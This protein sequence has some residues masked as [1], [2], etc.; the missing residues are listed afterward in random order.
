[1]PESR[2]TIE[3]LR[4]RLQTLLQQDSGADVSAVLSAEEVSRLDIDQRQTLFRELLTI[5]VDHRRRFGLAVDQAGYEQRFAAYREVIREVLRGPGSAAGGDDDDEA[6]TVGLANDE[7][8]TPV[9]LANRYTNLRFHARGGL[10]E[11]FRAHD[12]AL[13]RDIAVKFIRPQR[14]AE[15]AS[16]EQFLLEGEITGRLDHPGVV[17]VYG[18][19]ETFDGRSFLAMRFIDGK[20]MRAVIDEFHARPAAAPG[21]RRRELNRL[22]NHL[23]AACNVVAYAHSRGILHR[24]IKPDNIMI[25]RFNETLVVDW[26][27]AVPIERDERGRASGEQTIHVASGS[28]DSRS[29]PAAGTIGYFSPEALDSHAVACG[30]ASDIYSLGG[31]LY[32]LLTGRRSV[33]GGV[34]AETLAAIRTGSFPAPRAVDR[35]IP[36]PLDAVCRKAM[37]VSPADRYAS[38]LNLAA[39]LE[40]FVADEPV[41]V[42]EETM[43]ERL[44][45]T[46][47]N[48]RGL[49]LSALAGLVAVAVVSGLTSV[50]L[51]QREVRERQLREVADGARAV[52][53]A[54]EQDGVRLAANF[55]AQTVAGEID[56]HWRILE[57]L[58]ADPIVR[59][60]LGD[61]AAGGDAETIRGELQRWLL[62]RVQEYDSLG[63]DSWFIMSGAGE[64][65]A[66]RPF[67]EKTV[68]KSYA[69][70][71][72][73]HGL[74]RELA[75]GSTDVEP[76]RGPHLSRAY[77][78]SSDG[79]LKIAYSVPV[80]PL[81][82][83]PGRSRPVG[84]LA[85]TAKAG[86]FSI[87]HRG[88]SGGQVGVLV[89]MRGPGGDDPPGLVLHHPNLR[90]LQIAAIERGEGV[91]KFLPAETVGRLD[92]QLKR[93]R[94]G[95]T[96]DVIEPHYI[97]SLADDPAAEW[98]AA[99]E[100]VVIANRPADRPELRYPGLVVIVELCPTPAAEGPP[101]AP[102][103]RR[104]PPP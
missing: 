99:F 25:G 5:E 61:L 80:W 73:F 76:I 62:E 71:D 101:A 8:Q 77:D 42:L 98:I 10:G 67:E 58:A 81:A 17:P 49:V 78:S 23:V 86:D 54:A 18:L 45:R 34:T 56:V 35:N 95:D 29:Q 30:T 102:D 94:M 100:P 38:P 44:R 15:A 63:A 96:D 92:L 11:V 41:S 40:A 2:Q 70:R 53:E 13:H 59:G 90:A 88:L 103:G 22:L 21:E 4:D 104:S 47:R 37:A 24:D 64:Q 55:A 9:T 57:A 16:R 68:G 52:A 65:L 75:E 89:D 7:Q 91:R 43:F 82:G 83:G 60:R 51:R 1:M 97:D 48:H 93:A 6:A 14:A 33:S 79:S 66:R 27:L 36:R 31:T 12:D 69:T 50:W 87:L 19:G 3:R 32:Y 74:G 72:Y 20:T 85:M 84:V 26:G 39:D 46:A 28:G